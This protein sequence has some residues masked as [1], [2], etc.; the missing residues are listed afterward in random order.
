MTKGKPLDDRM[1][2]AINS[3]INAELYSAYLYLA[4][5]AWFDSR[6]L[7]GMCGWMKLQAS[8]E[9]EHAMKLFDYLC[10]RG[11]RV[12]L[13]AIEKPVGEWESPLAAFEA[14]YE[15]E[16]HVTSLIHGLVD[17]AMELNDH[18]TRSM[19]SWF[20]DEQVEEESAADSIVQKLRMIDSPRGGMLLMIDREL[21]KRE[22]H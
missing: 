18:A 9:V 17:L 8:E 4:M 13:D 11:G 3:Q 20:V 21:G 6:D 15:H 10:E 22:A 1:Q 14:A 5:S 19:L 7:P 16:L 12:A 2:S